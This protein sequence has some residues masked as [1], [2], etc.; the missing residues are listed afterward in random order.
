MLSAFEGVGSKDQVKKIEMLN[1][2]KKRMDE[3]NLEL[4]K[5]MA[6]YRKS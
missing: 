5:V 6:E 1:K 4:K 3:K 2:I